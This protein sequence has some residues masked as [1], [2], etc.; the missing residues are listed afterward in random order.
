MQL[1]QA[2]TELILEQISLGCNVARMQ[3]KYAKVNNRI[4]KV[5]PT[6]N[7]TNPLVF[8]RSMAHNL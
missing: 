4:K 7:S 8:L 2:N 1:E 6:Y 5:L 3:K